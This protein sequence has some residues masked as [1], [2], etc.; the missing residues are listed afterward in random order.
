ML[1]QTV[2]NIRSRSSTE[3]FRI[4]FFQRFDWSV[5]GDPIPSDEG[6]IIGT[7]VVVSEAKGIDVAET[8]DRVSAGSEGGF[9]TVNTMVG[10]MTTSG[11]AGGLR[12]ARI[13][14]GRSTGDGRV[15]G[16]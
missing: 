11:G 7:V 9:L 4:R 13:A 10:M 14:D 5:A 15:G 12:R 1:L 2:P 8:V 3:C 6:S 16:G